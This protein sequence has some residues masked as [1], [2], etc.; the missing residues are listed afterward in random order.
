MCDLFPANNFI[1]CDEL[2]QFAVHLFFGNKFLPKS[3][4]NWLVSLQVLRKK[5]SSFSNMAF[6]CIHGWQYLH[7]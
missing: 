3:T 1:P 6:A 4:N 7:Y 2:Y 5:H